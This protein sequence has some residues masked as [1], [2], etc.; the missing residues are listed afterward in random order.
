MQH[1][2][3]KCSDEL[4]MESFCNNYAI[5]ATPA[6]KKIKNNANKINNALTNKSNAKNNNN[7]KISVRIK[8]VRVIVIA[9]TQ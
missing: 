8:I 6:C 9:T 5:I 4:S 3:Q 2:V 1:F 7:M